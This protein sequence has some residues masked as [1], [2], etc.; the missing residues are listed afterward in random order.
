MRIRK[1][2]KN[3]L[4]QIDIMLREH[5]LLRPVTKSEELEIKKH[6]RI[7]KLQKEDQKLDK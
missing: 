4:S 2:I 1:K 5:K 7:A 3:Y 6:E